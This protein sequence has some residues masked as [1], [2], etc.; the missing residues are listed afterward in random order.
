MV[1]WMGQPQLVAIVGRTLVTLT[2][3]RYC[4]TGGSLPSDGVEGRDG[5][6]HQ[7]GGAD[8]RTPARHPHKAANIEN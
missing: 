7:T 3:Y 2:H 1:D 4:R 5:C 8:A 6:N